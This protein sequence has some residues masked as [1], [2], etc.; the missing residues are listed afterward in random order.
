M[1]LYEFLEKGGV[2]MVPIALGSVV[3]L[4]LFLERVWS[5]Q[6]RLVAPPGFFRAVLLLLQQR[7]PGRAESLCA[8]NGTPLAQIAAAGLRK[9]GA[10][11][12]AMREAMEAAG[13]DAVARLGRPVGVLGVVATIE[14]LLGLLGTVTGM[15]KVFMD[16]SELQDPQISV[17]ARGIWE[18]LITTAAG[19]IVAV[20]SYVGYRY[21]TARVDALA[22]E[23]ENAGVEF[24]S[25]V[26]EAGLAAEDTQRPEAAATA[27]ANA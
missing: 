1:T 12:T 27:A 8:E 24:V 9:R 26:I 17:L 10:G 4:A 15:M 20:P 6:R 3:A 16:I 13:K 21:L 2:I 11:R 18:A 7:E 25:T 23:L 22:G 5:L 14:P 19:L